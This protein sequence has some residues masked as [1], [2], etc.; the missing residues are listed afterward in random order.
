MGNFLKAAYAALSHTY[1]YLSPDQWAVTK[2]TKSPYQEFT[3][4][5]KDGK[6]GSRG[7]KFVDDRE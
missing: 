1:S 7:K 3:D 2:F 6:S 4:F 5:L